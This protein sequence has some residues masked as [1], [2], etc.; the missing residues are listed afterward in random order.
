MMC[1]S[2]GH[3]EVG[4]NACGMWIE[5]A[6]TTPGTIHPQI[7]S[8]TKIC[9][10]ISNIFSKIS[11][12]EQEGSAKHRTQYL[13]C[14]A[15]AAAA[16]ALT[17]QVAQRDSHT[18]LVEVCHVHQLAEPMPGR[19]ASKGSKT[20]TRAHTVAEFDAWRSQQELAAKSRSSRAHGG[21]A[22]P[23]GTAA[24]GGGGAPYHHRRRTSSGWSGGTGRSNDAVGVGAA[25]AAAT[26]PL[27]PLTKV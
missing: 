6:K 23:A 20:P 7:I 11:I 25:A 22:A 18:P 3:W 1:Y 21:M 8:S 24:D 26:R 12:Q 19:T 17:A 13:G 16:A 27:L 9:S 10:S 5:L 4:T 2:R 14:T 15:A